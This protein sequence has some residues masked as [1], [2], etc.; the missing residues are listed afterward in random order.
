MV[1]CLFYCSSLF[2]VLTDHIQI[3][4]GV[5]LMKKDVQKIHLHMTSTEVL[6]GRVGFMRSILVVLLRHIFL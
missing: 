4:Y 5:I 6:N 3:A 1:Y 2:C